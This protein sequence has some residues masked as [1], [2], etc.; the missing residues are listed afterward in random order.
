[1]LFSFN[2][3]ACPGFTTKLRLF[4]GALGSTSTSGFRFSNQVL[5]INKLLPAYVLVVRVLLRGLYKRDWIN[6]Q[7]PIVYKGMRLSPSLCSEWKLLIA[8]YGVVSG[9]ACPIEVWN[10]QYIN[11]L[12]TFGSNLCNSFCFTCTFGF[13][14]VEVPVDISQFL[15]HSNFHF[16]RG[17][18]PIIN[19]SNF[20]F[21]NVERCYRLKSY[22]FYI[23]FRKHNW[24]YGTRCSYKLVCALA[25]TQCA[26]TFSSGRLD[27]GRMADFRRKV[28]IGSL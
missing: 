25:L 24:V 26:P 16:P 21:S 27:L 6:W 12:G 3:P 5:N 9:P 2:L 17:P 13:C 4:P 11:H 23:D 20:F 8:A 22:I 15:G 14:F 1:M 10:S 7:E 28:S 18:I 19:L